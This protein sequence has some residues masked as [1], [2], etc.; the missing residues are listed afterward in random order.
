MNASKLLTT[1]VAALTVVGA[2]LVYAQTT[3]PGAPTGT[4]EPANQSQM[5]TPPA[6][7]MQSPAP[8]TPAQDTT[9]RSTA[10][11]TT[12]AQADRN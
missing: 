9:Q 1:A 7:N 5:G 3:T 6:T 8:T 2:G 4:P 12:D 10:P 11:M